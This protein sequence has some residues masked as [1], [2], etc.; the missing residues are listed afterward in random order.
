MYAGAGTH[1]GAGRPGLWIRS[2]HVTQD[3]LVHAEPAR[4]FVPP[5]VGPKGWVGAYLDGTPDWS[6]LTDLVR[7]AHRGLIPARRRLA[8]GL[9]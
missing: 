2:A 7:D 4:Y 5:Y 9:G 8:L 6:A 3:M 1:H